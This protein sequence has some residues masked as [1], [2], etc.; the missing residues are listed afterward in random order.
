MKYN[1]LYKNLL[2]IV[3]ADSLLYILS[4]Y[5]AYLLK[6][7][8]HIPETS[9]G[10]LVRTL[11]LIV[12]TKII[13]FYYF[14]LYRGMWR[15]TSIDDLFNIIKASFTSMLIIFFL[16]MFTHRFAGFARSVFIIDLG[17]TI[18]LISGFRL[19]V[20]LF[21]WFDSGKDSA[22]IIA[23]RIIGFKGNKNDDRKRLLI[24]GAGDCG[25]KICREIRDN[26]KLSY[27]VVGFID[28]NHDKLNKQIHSISVY[29]TTNDL[30]A[31]TDKLK[32]DEILIAISARSPVQMR[33]I[34]S[35]CKLTNLPY[36]TLPGM[37]ELINGEVTINAIRDV[38]YRD[39]LGRSV[40]K[41]E[42]ERI[43]AYLENAR[44]LVTGAGGSIGSELCRQICRFRPKSI[45][46]LERAE[47]Y[48]YAIELE[49]EKDY[50][51]IKIVSTLADIRDRRQL[52][53]AFE[54]FRPQV[55]FHAA[56]Y[57][58]V[59]M[60]ELQPWKAVKNNIIGTRNVIDIAKQY[61]VKRF[62]FVSTDKAV[63]PTNVMGACKRT[64][65]L[66]V[67][68]QK[69]GSE[70][71]DKH[72]M[73]VRFGNVVGSV[74]SVVPLFKK[75]IENGGPV[76][77]THPEVTRY[78]M[79]IPEA[80]Q[81]ILQAGAMGKGGETFILDMGRP[82]KIVDMARDLI[83]LSGF[84]PEV[85]IKIEYT[86]LRP[87]EKLYEELIT[88]GEGIVPTSHE[89]ILVL[90]GQACDQTILNN[91]IDKMAKLA[92]LQDVNGIRTKL[93]EIVPEYQPQNGYE[94]NETNSKNEKI[95]FI[96]NKSV[97]FLDQTQKNKGVT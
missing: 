12:L 80:C 88:D 49:L 60:M 2:L 17:L 85:D 1:F 46:L 51:Y 53:L 57:K 61:K 35:R 93:R 79:T 25:E 6:F 97:I 62:V 16:V 21:F 14:N 4:W 5:S 74:G 41:L 63:R 29:G 27:K 3:G 68:G 20:R 23:E 18:M 72:F 94:T 95:S 77:V 34:I 8:F 67:Q 40:I 65:E 71:S 75:Q 89:K 45:N 73:I 58:H 83:R 11:P 24:I 76:T 90:K 28:D 82:I 22:K 19:T 50:P 38:D 26:T 66:I 69:N 13:I 78:F 43:G 42:E 37:G 15:Y 31:I 92:Y 44:V 70:N 56:A 84:E 48:L 54:S 33:D 30:N 81:L 47:S 32:V 9:I 87:G 55:I 86:G 96:Q 39:L 36:K 7:N 59:P 52:S 10:I 91:Q 64:A